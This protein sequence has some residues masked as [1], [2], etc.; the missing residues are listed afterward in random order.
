[1]SSNTVNLG[2][3]IDEKNES[4]TLKICILKIDINW[5]MVTFKL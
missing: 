2:Q 3:Y 5:K 1:M 4:K